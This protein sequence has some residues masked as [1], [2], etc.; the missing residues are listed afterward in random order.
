MSEPNLVRPDMLAIVN[1]P[2]ARKTSYPITASDIRRWAI[3]VHYPDTPP[4]PYLDPRAP[5]DGRL[6]APLDF[7]PFAWG[8][9]HTERTGREIPPDPSLRNSG[10]MEH[11]LGVA[12]P[13]LPH[14]LNGGVAA[15]YTRVAM[16]PGD[17]ITAETVIAGYSA[18]KGRL[19]AMLLTE[20]ATTWTNQRAEIVKVH[21]MTL[22]RY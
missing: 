19:G 13:D 17:V 10:A 16:R 3:A 20:T 12:P 4:D 22:I 11:H 7:N 14:A 15:T 8:A 9:A 2:Y 5:E 1:Q 21:R 6:T 18:K